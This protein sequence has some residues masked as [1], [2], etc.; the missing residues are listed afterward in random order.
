VTGGAYSTILTEEKRAKCWLEN[1]KE[2]DHLGDLGRDGGGKRWTSFIQLRAGTNGTAAES[3]V[4]SYEFPENV[5]FLEH[6]LAYQ[7]CSYMTDDWFQS[8]TN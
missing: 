5:E 3:L 1:L 2:G 7:G 8:V 4:M 6:L